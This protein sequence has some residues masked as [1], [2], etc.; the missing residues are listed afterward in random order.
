[1]G[2]N[3]NLHVLNFKRRKE[4]LRF[5]LALKDDAFWVR[6]LRSKYKMKEWLPINIARG[7]YSF[8]WRALAKG[9]AT[10]RYC[11]KNSEHSSFSSFSRSK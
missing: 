1:M 3:Y 2:R 10:R 8:I 6:V 5:N 9:L 4:K 7:N 11:Q